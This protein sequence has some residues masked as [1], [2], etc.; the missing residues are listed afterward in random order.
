MDFRRISDQDGFQTRVVADSHSQPIERLPRELLN[1]IFSMLSGALIPKI[2]EARDVIG[3]MR[4]ST[5]WKNVVLRSKEIKKN[6][7]IARVNKILDSIGDVR[8]KAGSLHDIAIV[9]ASSGDI[10][11]ALATA[12]LISDRSQKA[13]AI[14]KIAYKESSSQGLQTLSQVS[15]L[16]DAIE[17][18]NNKIFIQNQMVVAYADFGNKEQAALLFSQIKTAATNM[19]DPQYSS[20]ILRDIVYTQIKLGEVEEALAT[21]ASITNPSEKSEALCV[22]AKYYAG[23]GNFEKAKAIAQNI[24]DQDQRV[25]SLCD[26]AAIQMTKGDA[27]GAKVSFN[28]AK[29]M[30][31]E[32]EELLLKDEMLSEISSSQARAQ[33]IEDALITAEDICDAYQKDYAFLSIAS[34]QA[35]LGL[36]EKAKATLININD[37]GLYRKTLVAITSAQA[38]AGDMEGA[39]KTLLS[40]PDEYNQSSALSEIVIAYVNAGHIEQAEKIVSTIVDPSLKIKVLLKIY[41][42]L[43]VLAK[44]GTVS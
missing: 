28:Q 8:V 30:C 38:K 4:V 12:E 31:D 37:F 40:I 21:A 17:R 43:G 2:D 16:A 23:T 7:L 13:F 10:E 9:R 11:G 25:A 20:E 39:Q 18:V 15:L 42:A 34:A 19:I 1:R 36:V 24:E 27:A 29:E 14:I 44:K 35:K 6:L 41:S 32:I 5:I 3:V 22:I 33:Y 26:I